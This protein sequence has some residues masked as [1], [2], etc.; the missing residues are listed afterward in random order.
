MH[1]DVLAR[2]RTWLFSVQHSI[3]V[4]TTCMVSSCWKGSSPTLPVPL[5]P[6]STLQCLSMASNTL[7]NLANVKVRPNPQSD[8]RPNNPHDNRILYSTVGQKCQS[9]H[10]VH[11]STLRQ[12]HGPAQ[13]LTYATTTTW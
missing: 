10:P 12:L 1:A 6:A 3:Y 9:Q 8:C 13:A 2:S 7:Q 11:G 5:Y 4:S